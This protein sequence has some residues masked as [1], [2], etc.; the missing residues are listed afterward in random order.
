MEYGDSQSTEGDESK[1]GDEEGDYS[2]LVE[3]L[4]LELSYLKTPKTP[5]PT[6][7]LTGICN[8]IEK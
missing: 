6:G 3:E 7:I 2:K 4:D 8:M 5:E 1:D